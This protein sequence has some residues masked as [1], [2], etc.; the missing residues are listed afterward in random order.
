MTIVPVPPF[1]LANGEVADATQLMA[2]LNS[3]VQNVNANAAHN[4]VNNDITALTAL[5]VPLSPAQGGTGTTAPIPPSGYVL[6][7][8][9][10][11]Y[12]PQPVGAAV[13][14]ATIPITDITTNNVSTS[15]HG[16]CPKSP[17][18]ASVFLDGTGNYSAPP[19][20][21]YSGAVVTKSASQ[22]IPMNVTTALTFDQETI[23][24]DGFHDNV[25]NNTRFTIPSG[26]SAVRFFAG[27]NFSGTTVGGDYSI[28][29]V[30]NGGSGVAAVDQTLQVTYGT[31]FNLASPLILCSPGDYFELFFASSTSANPTVGNGATTFFEIQVLG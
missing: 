24:T 13:T 4:G 5:T 25:T 8:N 19:S 28:R 21:A 2:N 12:I 1:T 9:G 14:D 17:N 31:I 10:T 27:V 23:D 29:V 20:L 22:T 18:N 3:A 11:T 30:K 15:K 6:V 7:S 26:V 16:F